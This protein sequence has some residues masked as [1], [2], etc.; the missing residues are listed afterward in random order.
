[1][2]KIVLAIAATMMILSASAQDNNNADGRQGRRFDR[3]EMQKRQIENMVK[4]YGLNEEQTKQITALNEKYGDKLMGGFGGM[5]GGFRGGPGMGQ[6]NRG[7]RQ[8]G[9]RPELTE[10]QRQ[11]MEARRKEAEQARQEYDAELQKIMTPE[12]FTKYKADQE[13]RANRMPRGERRGQRP[14]NNQ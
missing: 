4:Q 8:Q 3:T 13:E 5:R 11:Q 7:P 9:Q 14:N 1:M 6:G 2:K 10:E 12:Q